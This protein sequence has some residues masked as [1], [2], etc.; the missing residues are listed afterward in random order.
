MNKTM[1]FCISFINI[2]VKTLNHY[3]HENYKI[4][5]WLNAVNYLP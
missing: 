1:G 5:T 4:P 3:S 2:L